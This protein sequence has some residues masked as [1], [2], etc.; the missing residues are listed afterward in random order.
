[1]AGAARRPSQPVAPLVQGE[2]Q[3]HPPRGA[4]ETSPGLPPG[5]RRGGLRLAPP[6]PS[7]PR[8]GLSQ[9]GFVP[10]GSARSSPPPP[11]PSPGA[12][13]SRPRGSHRPPVDAGGGRTGL[14][15]LPPPGSGSG[16]HRASG[17]RGPAWAGGSGS[18][19]S[20]RPRGRPHGAAP[21][22]RSAPGTHAWHRRAPPVRAPAG[23]HG[24]IPGA[25]MGPE[26]S[27]DPKFLPARGG[28]GHGEG[29]WGR[30]GSP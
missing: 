21:P 29:R 8:R 11:K 5:A 2:Q 1:M 17:E 3:A 16:G 23:G 10:G 20:D 30:F 26:S 24:W 13:R 12:A 18:P 7:R 9:P 6:T 22:A 4:A 14:G 19:A 27:G 25:E 28:W 15:S